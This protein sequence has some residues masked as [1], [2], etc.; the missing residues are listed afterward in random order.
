[1]PPTAY[2]RPLL[3]TGFC[4]ALTTFSTVQIELLDLIDAGR[5][6]ARGLLRADQ[7]RARLRG[8]RPCLGAGATRMI[9]WLGLAMAGG[10]GAVARFLVDGAVSDRL[11]RALP[12]G[13]LAVNLS[14]AFAL[15]VLSG[16]FV[17]GT[18]FVGAYTTFSTWMLETQRLAEDGRSAA[19]LANVFGS[20]VLG[21][22]AA[23]LGASL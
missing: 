16:N 3:G 7:H 8:R 20:L 17:V 11:G 6:R 9:A 18:G 12:L 1:M 21:L 15:G 4:G 22:G 19:A 13:T 2:R 23:A 14:G 10:L 5:C